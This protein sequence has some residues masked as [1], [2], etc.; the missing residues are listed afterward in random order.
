MSEVVQS[1]VGFY[2]FGRVFSGKVSTSKKCRIMGPKGSFSG[3]PIKHVVITTGLDF[4]TIGEVPCGNVCG[5]F[6][7]DQFLEESGTISTFSDA[8]QLKIHENVVIEGLNNFGGAAGL[9][10]SVCAIYSIAFF[11][12]FADLYFLSC[13]SHLFH[14]HFLH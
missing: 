11:Y 10:G 2:A 13:H 12:S 1:D 14:N 4:E 9:V 6:G 3:K 8:H 5:L 7:V